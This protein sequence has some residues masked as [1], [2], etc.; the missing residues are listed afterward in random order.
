MKATLTTSGSRVVLTG[1]TYKE[2]EMLKTFPAM[3]K[4]TLPL[5]PKVL[6]FCIAR[7]KK[8][9]SLGIGT[10]KEVVDAIAQARSHQ[11]QTFQYHPD[12][13]FHTKPLSH[14][15]FCLRKALEVGSIGLLLDPGLGKTKVTLDFI[16]HNK[17]ENPSTFTKALIICPKA[18][19]KTWVNEVAKHRPELK[20]Y[21]V[22]SVSH[23]D[24]IEYISGKVATKSW[25]E[26]KC[27]WGLREIE[28]LKLALLEENK[29]FDSAD[30]IVMNYA[31]VTKAAE[32]LKK[33]QWTT[34]AVDEALIKDPKSLRT[35]AVLSLSGSARNRLLLSGTLINQGP[36]DV[37][38]PTQFLEPAIF[39]TSFWNF[40]K[41]YGIF[42]KNKEKGSE[43]LVGYKRGGREEIRAGLELVSIVMSKDEWLPDLPKKMPP[44]FFLSDLT[45]DQQ[46]CYDEL[47]TNYITR[48]PSGETVEVDNPLSCLCK[49]QQ[50]ANG[51]VYFHEE[52][53]DLTDLG[54]AKV[55]DKE[56]K[57]PR[58]PRQTYFF[59]HNPKN[60]SLVNFLIAP[61]FKTR[62]VVLWYNMGAE[63]VQIE[64]TL[65]DLGV[66]YVIVNGATKDSGSVVDEFNSNPTIQVFVAQ[67]KSVNYGVTLLGVDLDEL[68]SAPELDPEVY[69]E[70]FY[71]VNYS[72]EVYLQQLDR[73]H[74]IGVKCRPEYY[75]SRSNCL[76]ELR[77]QEKLDEKQLIRREFLVDIIHQHKKPGSFED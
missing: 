57:K 63:L 64:R 41:H 37:F 4:N 74:R 65:F 13:Y 23:R 8:M 10:T 55:T 11:T 75:F 70:Y 45:E 48:L 67:A 9:T 47:S 7:L 42:S 31:K 43:F 12:F 40:N 26:K 2:Q 25:D 54:L 15:D 34:V 27:R 33:F 21:V 61:E 36:E 52:D 66:K 16:F 50:I 6:D 5:K 49:L 19:L 35:K 59:G 44:V 14:Q 68:D 69:T 39:G 28:K 60:D 17:V 30:I 1:T 72:L 71:S 77:I 58:G 18:L 38:A 76:I 56:N 46:R 53:D 20:I 29:A 32:R 62:R 3:V 22:Q 24:S 73:V 51:F